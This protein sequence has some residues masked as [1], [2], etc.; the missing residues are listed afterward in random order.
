MVTDEAA[1]W[2]SRFRL[3]I[4]LFR[5]SKSD[6]AHL[7]DRATF[8]TKLES[9]GFPSTFEELEAL[10]HV[11][12]DQNAAGDYLLAFE[13]MAQVGQD[14]LKVIAQK[15]VRSDLMGSVVEHIDRAL[16]HPSCAFDKDWRKGI[17]VDFSQ[18]MK[19]KRLSEVCLA[20]AELAHAEGNTEGTFRELDRALGVAVHAR[21]PAIISCVSSIAIE[22]KTLRALA[23]LSAAD[24]KRTEFLESAR[25]WLRRL[26]PLPDRKTALAFELLL[27]SQVLADGDRKGMQSGVELDKW[28]PTRGLV[29]LI[30]RNDTS[31]RLVMD[32]FYDR[33]LRHLDWSDGSAVQTVSHWG[34]YDDPPTWRADEFEH[35]AWLMQSPYSSH[36]FAWVRAEQLRELV[37]DLLTF[38]SEAHTFEERKQWRLP[39]GDPSLGRKLCLFRRNELTLGF[40]NTVLVGRPESGTVL[41]VKLPQD[42]PS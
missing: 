5:S 28:E 3:L 14:L 9:Y 34:E 37:G 32:R 31:R 6:T 33:L 19:M 2:K 27:I 38:L 21:E 24:P 13:A 1:L 16:S 7:I 10:C 17:D 35:V 23:R 11:P 8:L 25:D 39:Y 12:P 40:T 18:L 22:M 29:A 4:G 36:F 42:A 15:Q 26:P 30:L 41:Y 20:R